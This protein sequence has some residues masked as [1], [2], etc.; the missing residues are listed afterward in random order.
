MIPHDKRLR[1]AA[2]NGGLIAR[3]SKDPCIGLSPA[4]VGGK[5]IEPASA[6][7]PL[8]PRR[9]KGP[10]LLQTPKFTPIPSATLGS[11]F[12]SWL[13][14]RLAGDGGSAVRLLEPSAQSLA[15][16][17]R[18]ICRIIVREAVARE[19]GGEEWGSAICSSR[20]KE[21]RQ[22]GLI[23]CFRLAPGRPFSYKLT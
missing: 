23:T 12:I 13:D 9:K 16:R 11:N 10:H 4:I 22:S 14:W 1:R 21:R 19:R 3:G 8:L 6:P 2:G 15:R 20:P 7:N 17:E 5:N 18:Q